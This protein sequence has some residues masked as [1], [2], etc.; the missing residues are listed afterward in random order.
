MVQD[1]LSECALDLVTVATSVV[2]MH[3]A[4]H[5]GIVTV[6]TSVVAM[7]WRIVV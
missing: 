2:A 5:S 3:Q 7:P 4:I 6:A 1:L